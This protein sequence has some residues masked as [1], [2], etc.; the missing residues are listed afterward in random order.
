[1]QQQQAQ[2]Q[3]AIAQEKQTKPIEDIQRKIVNKMTSQAAERII[4]QGATNV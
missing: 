4:N 3:N 2:E 1:M